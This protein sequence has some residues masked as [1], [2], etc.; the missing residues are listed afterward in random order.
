MEW[1]LI[2]LGLL[3]FSK[4]AQSSRIHE[5]IVRQQRETN[6][7]LRRIRQQAA[8]ARISKLIL[9]QHGMT[10]DEYGSRYGLPLDWLRSW[11]REVNNAV[12]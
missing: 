12:R 2:I 3:I 1:F 4:L 9:F 5:E 6:K 11:S 8:W 10:I 7:H